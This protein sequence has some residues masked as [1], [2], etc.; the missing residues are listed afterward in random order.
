MY[1]FRKFYIDGAWVAPAGRRE[2]DDINPA[3]EA[4]VGKILLGTADDVDTAVRAARAAFESF[5]QTSREERVPLRE[6]I[7]KALQANLPRLAAAISDEMGAPAKFALN[8]QA[9]SG[10]GHFMTTLAVLKDFEFEE[11]LGTT[12]V[13]R[14]PVGVCGMIT[15]W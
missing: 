14:E 3:T 8:A 2:H 9:A 7:V 1:D 10:L 11:T 4:P 15:P 13:R 5:S 6:R 12:Q